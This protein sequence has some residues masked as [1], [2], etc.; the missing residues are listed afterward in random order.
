MY[1]QARYLDPGLGRF[2]SAD[3]FAGTLDDPFST[4][5]FIYGRANPL[6]Y[7]DPDGR[8]DIVWAE[9]G[10]EAHQEE[11]R[12]EQEGYQARCRARDESA[13]NQLL[14][15]GAVS[16]LYMAGMAV[17]AAGAAAVVAT[18]LGIAAAFSAAK[19]KVLGIFAS[20]GG[21]AAAVETAG[22]VVSTGI[23]AAQCSDANPRACL[24]AVAGAVDAVSGLPLPAAEFGAA[25]QLARK[26]A[27]RGRGGSGGGGG[28]SDDDGPI[29]DPTR[30]LRPGIRERME[31]RAAKDAEAMSAPVGP[32]EGLPPRRDMVGGRLGNNQ[33]RH[34]AGTN[35]H[36]ANPSRSFFRNEA[37]AQKVLEA[38]HANRGTVLSYDARN[39]AVLFEYPG[40]VGV[41]RTRAKPDTPTNRF[42]IKGKG[43]RDRASIFPAA[44]DRQ[45]ID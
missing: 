18:E 29:V 43:K 6:K 38:F 17:V 2:L 8:L 25:D 37:E 40:A 32:F 21:G 1:A 42:V 10:L 36:E 9:K 4:Q 30:L 7:V 22:D 35:E 24:E 3:P 33:R 26:D 27:L 31:R 11:Y 5:G 44:P 41:Y 13:C 39:N 15:R 23:A 34:V 28:A 19:A 20:L 45:S 12:K 14:G 16:T